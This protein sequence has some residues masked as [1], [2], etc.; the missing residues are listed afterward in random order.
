MEKYTYRTLKISGSSEDV[1]M[2]L[3]REYII[4]HEVN[5]NAYQYEFINIITGISE[6]LKG[7]LYY[8]R[9]CT[10]IPGYERTSE[11]LIHKQLINDNLNFY[12]PTP[13]SGR[14]QNDNYLKSFWF[15]SRIIHKSDTEMVI[16]Y[17]LDEGVD[18][19]FWKNYLHDVYP[20]LSF[21]HS[22]IELDSEI[23]Y[24]NS[25]MIYNHGCEID[26]EDYP[27]DFLRADLD[28]I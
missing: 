27:E 24:Y 21:G 17:I 19:S 22:M 8:R 2:C 6:Q 5:V 1:K 16:A 11:G 9:K 13:Y 7:I 18:T 26:D 28:L 20:L 3:D 23:I 25:S 10:I 15:E 12:D 14:A 4:F